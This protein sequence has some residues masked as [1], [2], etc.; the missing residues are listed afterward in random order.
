MS[1]MRTFPPYSALQ[2]CQCAH[3]RRLQRSEP[4][5]GQVDAF[6]HCLGRQRI[7][8]FGLRVV[9]LGEACVEH[10]VCR[11]AGLGET[12]EQRTR[13]GQAICRRESSRITR[14]SASFSFGARSAKPSI[15]LPITGIM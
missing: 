15:Q 4:Q 2:A 14:N 5:L 9:G 8:G 12:V 1:Q 10:D 13:P 7:D 11:R 3:H 6:V